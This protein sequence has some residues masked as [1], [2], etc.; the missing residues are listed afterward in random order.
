MQRFVKRV[1]AECQ[2][3]LGHLHLFG[4]QGPRALLLTLLFLLQN[5]LQAALVW[6]KHGYHSLLLDGALIEATLLI[7]CT[8]LVRFAWR[9]RDRG[10]LLAVSRRGNRKSIR[11]L[12]VRPIRQFTGS[13]CQSAPRR[14][15]THRLPRT[16]TLPSS[17]SLTLHHL[18]LLLFH[19]HNIRE[20]P[21]CLA[22][23]PERLCL[24][25]H[26]RTYHLLL[27]PILFPNRH[28]LSA[29]LALLIRRTADTTTL[30]SMHIVPWFF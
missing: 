10:K 21:P 12:R 11:L 23:S 30:I 6:F 18:L 29:D 27:F 19:K 2:L 5:N 4:T 28:I 24:P 13:R 25:L 15:R 3:N 7:Y 17:S 14:H 8:F 26:H 9:N 16:T 1:L 20:P 22:T